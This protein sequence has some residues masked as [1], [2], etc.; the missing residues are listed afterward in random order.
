M[1]TGCC[2]NIIEVLSKDGGAVVNMDIEVPN[3]VKMGVGVEDRF[4][5]AGELV[6]EASWCR[7]LVACCWWSIDS[8]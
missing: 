3:Y 7:L 1:Q 6:K 8:Y 4:Q 5:E 2:Q